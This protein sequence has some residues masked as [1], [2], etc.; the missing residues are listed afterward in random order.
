MYIILYNMLYFIFISHN[1]KLNIY[2]T[3]VNLFQG[4]AQTKFVITTGIA[5]LKCLLALFIS[6]IQIFLLC[7]QNDILHQKV[8]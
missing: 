6:I 7:S 3:I 2:I 5:L 1:F 8:I 4:I